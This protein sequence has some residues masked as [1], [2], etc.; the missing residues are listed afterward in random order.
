M[1]WFG[2]DEDVL[3]CRSASRKVGK[4][5]HLFLDQP[6]QGDATPHERGHGILMLDER[7]RV[8]GNGPTLD[9]IRAQVRSALAQ[10]GR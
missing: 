3:Q 9:E 10:G 1:V 5:L 8:R 4:E 6:A 7:G 2:C